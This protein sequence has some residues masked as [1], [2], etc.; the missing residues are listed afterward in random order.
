MGNL[1][2][3]VIGFGFTPQWF[4]V[5]RQRNFT[6]PGQAPSGSYVVLV[7]QHIAFKT[8]EFDDAG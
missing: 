5:V 4:P 1:S 8:F 2:M 6:D 3:K 7:M